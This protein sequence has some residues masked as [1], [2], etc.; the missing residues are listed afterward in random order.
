VALTRELDVPDR[1][2]GVMGAWG[3]GSFAND[4]AADW[5]AEL[6]ADGSLETVRD[7]L[8]AAA[9]TAPDDYLESPEGSEALAAAEVVAAAAGRPLDPNPDTEGA[10]EWAADHPEAAT[11]ELLALARSAVGRVAAEG[12]ELRELWLEAAPQDARDWQAALAALQ[13]R[14]GA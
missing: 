9:G 14:L 6:I 13:H 12:S 3:S 5:A 4:M 10:L 7:A 2:G 1:Y 11:Q 8:A